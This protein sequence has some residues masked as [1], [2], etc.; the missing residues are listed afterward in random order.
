MRVQVEKGQLQV[1]REFS[2][3]NSSKP[4]RTQINER[5]FEF[6][7]P[8]GAKIVEGSAM[9][10]H[11]NPLKSAPVLERD[12]NRHFFEF[13]LRPGTTRFQVIH[14]VPYAGVRT[15]IRDRRRSRSR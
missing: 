7:I 15:S 1:T 9:A 5:N 11:G 8:E 10:E 3:Q 12:K 6:Y 13:P 2:V 14:R 4:L